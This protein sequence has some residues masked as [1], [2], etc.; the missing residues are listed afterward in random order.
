MNSGQVNSNLK[1]LA[2]TSLI[3]FIGIL[4]SKLFSYIYRI[5]IVRQFGLEIYGRFTITV[6]LVTWFT[7]IAS[8]GLSEGALRFIALY[9]GQK[10]QDKI[11]SLLKSVFSILIITG[12]LSGVILFFLSDIISS[13]IFKDPGLIIFLKFSSIAVPFVTL[14]VIFTLT[15]AGMLIVPHSAAVTVG[16]VPNTGVI[17]VS[18]TLSR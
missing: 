3:V 16:N 7:T 12:I 2:K 18:F 17:L 4:L 13:G 11:K 9:R 5:I 10:S 6:M 1:L 15:V 8:L 14:G